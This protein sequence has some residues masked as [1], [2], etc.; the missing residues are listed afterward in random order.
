M[1]RIVSRILMLS[2]L[3]VATL[4]CG[5]PKPEAQTDAKKI[6]SPDESEPKQVEQADKQR[7]AWQREATPMPATFAGFP[8]PELAKLDGIWIVD[9]E[10]PSRGVVWEI[11]DEGSKLT[12]I[13]PHGRERIHGV[14]LSSPCALRLTDATGRAQARAIAQLDDALIISKRGA[15]AVAAE[16][17]SLLACIGHR[18]YQITADGRCRYT[19]EMLGVWSDPIEAT[20]AC[21][22]AKVAGKRVLTIAGQ[23]FEERD[24]SVWLDEVAAASV[25]SPVES[26]EAGI[27]ALTTDPD[28]ADGGDTGTT[29]SHS[30][31]E[32]EIGDETG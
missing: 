24:G 2:C 32:T 12:I 17:G 29:G 9:A 13:D 23:Q 21:K 31:S 30:G 1:L 16:D 26:R 4:A 7:P 15:I 10:R 20:N 19:T 11:E 3:T 6:E 22:L 18:T 27:A 5:R 8:R 14:T 25:A 28:A